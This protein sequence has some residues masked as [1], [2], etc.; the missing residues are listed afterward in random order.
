MRTSAE[1]PQGGSALAAG[2][3]AGGLGGAELGNDLIFPFDGPATGC[4]GREA[5]AILQCVR[6][7][8]LAW[9]GMLAIAGT[10][11]RMG[12]RHGCSSAL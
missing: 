4:L 5:R 3:S 9:G 1:P 7:A 11:A 6:K 2:A 10:T 8:G 12:I